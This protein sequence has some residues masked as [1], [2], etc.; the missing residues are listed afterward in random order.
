MLARYK[1]AVEKPGSA[2][3]G[4]EVF[5]RECASCHLAGNL[6]QIVGPAAGTFKDKPAAELLTAILDPNRE[7]DPRYLNYTVTLA[8]GR[9]TSGVIAGESP[10]A[11]VVRRVA[12]SL[13]NNA[14]SR[15]VPRT[16]AGNCSI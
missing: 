15:L 1:P 10:T 3:K 13:N 2:D 16:S 9:V 4:R 8:D 11:A 6:G 7:V 14:C 12:R 5:R